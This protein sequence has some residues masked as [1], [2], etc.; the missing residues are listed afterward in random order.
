MGDLPNRIRELRKAKGWTQEHLADEAG[1]SYVQISDLETGKRSL[2]P[3]WMKAISKALGV[4]SA[5]LL[6]H[7][8][9]SDSLSP[10]ERDLV[11][12]WRNATPEMREQFARVAEALMPC[13]P[14]RKAANS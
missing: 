7:E 13:D 14:R 2:R 6:N 12:R 3:V 1:C 8:D 9:N 4:K 10:E 11:E 5:D